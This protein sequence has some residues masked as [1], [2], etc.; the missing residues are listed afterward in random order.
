VQSTTDQSRCRLSRKNRNKQGVATGVCRYIYPTKK[1]VYLKKFM[2]LFFSCDPGQIRY[3]IC[4][5][6]IDN[7]LKLHW[8]VKTYTPK[9]NSWLRPRKQILQCSEIKRSGLKLNIQISWEV[10]CIDSIG[11]SSPAV[12]T[13]SVSLQPAGTCTLLL[14][15]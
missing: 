3:D 9:S 5:R 7:V 10:T 8:L 6:D 4:S 14:V 1:S 15:H 12:V 2:W 11:R 13:Y